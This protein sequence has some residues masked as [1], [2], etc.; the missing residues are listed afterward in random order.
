MG[1]YYPVLPS[2]TI[3]IQIYPTIEEIPAGLFVNNPALVSVDSIFS[4][5]TALTSIPDGLFT[6][7][8]NPKISN[9]RNAFSDCTGLT[10]AA[11][12][13]WNRYPSADGRY[14]FRNCTGLSNYASIPSNWKS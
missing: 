3:Y 5:C 11:P 12:D 14:C 2:H 9:F 6:K 1:I 8:K 7:A 4:R 13:L 10:G